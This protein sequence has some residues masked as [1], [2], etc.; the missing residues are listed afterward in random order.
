MQEDSEEEELE[1]A[2]QVSMQTSSGDSQATPRVGKG[3]GGGGE[4]HRLRPADYRLDCGEESPM[5]PSSPMSEV[6]PPEGV[7]ELGAP[8]GDEGHKEASG[9]TDVPGGAVGTVMMGPTEA[10]SW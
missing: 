4:P 5:L 3:K 1:E 2:K 7:Q 8:I 6:G 9:S 10:M